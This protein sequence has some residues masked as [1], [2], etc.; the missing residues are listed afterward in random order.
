MLK[1]SFHVY[2]GNSLA[3]DYV[4]SNWESLV[5]RFSL[6]NRYLG[7]LPGQVVSKYVSRFKRDEVNAFFNKYPEGG[8]GKVVELFCRSKVAYFRRLFCHVK[9]TYP[10]NSC[11]KITCAEGVIFISGTRSRKQALEKIDNNIKWLEKHQ[12]TIKRWLDRNA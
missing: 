5:K 9:Q 11:N 7:R 8:A 6:N 3:W 10:W 1:V 12:V 4:R 2:L